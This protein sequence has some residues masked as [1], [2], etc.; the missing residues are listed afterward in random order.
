M[1]EKNERELPSNRIATLFI[2]LNMF[3]VI[4][5]CVS[6]IMGRLI[7]YGHVPVAY[8]IIVGLG[9]AV[10]GLF[11]LVAAMFYLITTGG[12]MKEA[13]IANNL[14]L[15]VYKKTPK[16]KG[17]LFPWCMA[18]ILLLIALPVL[19]GAVHVGKVESHVHLAVSVVTLLLYIQTVRVMKR[20]F[21]E[22]RLLMAEAIEVINSSSGDDGK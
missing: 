21:H 1:E 22:D 5:V 11:G 7:G 8:H 14:P 18:V 10:L 12:S 6:I 2:Y 17:K 13:L 20:T 9:T 3:T 16:L 19:G 4:M 15:D